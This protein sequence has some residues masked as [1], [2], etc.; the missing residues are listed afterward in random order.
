ME[1]M[2]KGKIKFKTHCPKCDNDFSYTRDSIERDYYKI[3]W[4]VCPICANKCRHSMNPTTYLSIDTTEDGGENVG[5][6]GYIDAGALMK[7]CQNTK[8]GTIDCNDI[9]RFPRANVE[10]VTSDNVVPDTNS[11]D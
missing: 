5:H 6:Y 11:E 2:V 3:G 4:V 1:K 7:Y 9:A 8:D 10:P